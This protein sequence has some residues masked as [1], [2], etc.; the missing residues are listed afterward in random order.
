M[1]GHDIH[2]R[3]SANRLRIADLYDGLTD[4]QLRT[5]SLCTGWDL[6]TLLGHIVM[7]LTVSLVRL[8]VG[9]AR[10][11]S[12]H[13]A[14]SAIAVQLGQ[15]PTRELTALLRE[16]AQRRV[17]APGVGP[18]GQFVEAAFTCAT[19]LD[20]WAWTST[21]RSATGYRYCRGC[22]PGPQALGTFHAASSRG[23]PGRPQIANGRTGK[24]L[25]FK[26]Q[27][28]RWPWR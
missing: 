21:F 4:A 8:L 26:A 25:A 3:T 6:R 18:M 28:R 15:R 17:P 24:A 12:V 2:A 7:P 10:H 16:R 23:W 13:G 1:D 20:P 27:P 11:G 9:T 5:P 19:P 14:S 22:P